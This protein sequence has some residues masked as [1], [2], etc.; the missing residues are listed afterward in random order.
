MTSRVHA[1]AIG[2][3]AISLLTIFQLLLD[4]ISAKAPDE[5][6]SIPV[7]ETRFDEVKKAVPPDAVLGF[8]TDSSMADPNV[9]AEYFVAQYALA[10]RVVANRADQ[11]LVL[12]IIH[13]PTPRFPN[14]PMI[15]DFGNGI[16]L[17]RGLAR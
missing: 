17:Y 10:P 9:Q 11:K 12:G 8:I 7:F 15:R 3:L 1:A 16:R 5:S 2:L 4:A 13:N 14:L 6:A